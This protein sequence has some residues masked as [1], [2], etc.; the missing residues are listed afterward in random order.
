MLDSSTVVEMGECMSAPT[1]LRCPVA[2]NISIHH[3]FFSLLFKRYAPNLQTVSKFE[4]TS[5]FIV[6]KITFNE[7]PF[8]TVCPWEAI[9]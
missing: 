5:R 9:G 2:Q 7:R 6:E 3:L 1:Y 4:V 8:Y